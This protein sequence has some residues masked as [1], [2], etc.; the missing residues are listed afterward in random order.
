M[1]HSP[2]PKRYSES[3]A[4]P[5]RSSSG[6]I[7]EQLDKWGCTITV[8]EVLKFKVDKL[9][10]SLFASLSVLQVLLHFFF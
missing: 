9:A 5:A 3:W 8:R 2:A 6:C 1:A 4:F 10:Q 7:K